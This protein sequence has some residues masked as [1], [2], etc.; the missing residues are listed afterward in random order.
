MAAVTC[1]PQGGDDRREYLDAVIGQSKGIERELFLAMKARPDRALLDALGLVQREDIWPL[2][3]IQYPRKEPEPLHTDYGWARAVNDRSTLAWTGDSPAGSS[4]RQIYIFAGPYQAHGGS[5]STIILTDPSLNVT[6]WIAGPKDRRFHSAVFINPPAVRQLQVSYTARSEQVAWV[7]RYAFD[8]DHLTRTAAY[9]PMVQEAQS[10]LPRKP[11]FK[12]KQIVGGV[13]LNIGNCREV[14]DT[15]RDGIAYTLD[16][17]PKARR[18]R[19]LW[20]LQS[21]P[22]QVDYTA[23]YDRRRRTL[24]YTAHGSTSDS[25]PLIDQ[26]ER[27]TNVQEAT[28]RKLLAIPIGTLAP[29]EMR[30]WLR[31]VQKFGARRV[32]VRR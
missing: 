1:G 8:S 22:L 7:E 20:R 3:T 26:R 14:P 10:D 32:S 21:G 25:G 28:M 18:L 12:P 5:R 23:L 16:R 17:Y 4:S 24:T 15:V 30:D 27:F 9:S 13:E 19:F 6:S 11:V 31:G 2:G 29:K